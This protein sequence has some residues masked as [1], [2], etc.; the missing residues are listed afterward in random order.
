MKDSGSPERSADPR[1]RIVRARPDPAGAA[2][3]QLGQDGR[4]LERLRPECLRIALVDRPLERRREHV[5]VQDARVRVVEDRC[6]DGAG[7]ERLG[8][9]HE[10]LVERVLA[11]DEDGDAVSAAPRAAPLLAQRRDRAGERDRDRAVERADVDPELERVG[12]G[13]A[14]QLAGHQPPLD[15]APLRGRVAGAVGREPLRGLRVHALDGEAVDQLD[16]LA[17]LR[18]ADRAQAAL[19]EAGEQP[20][21]LAERA[22]P[23]PEL[24]I[25]ERRVPE[26]DRPLRPR[27]RIALDHR[28]RLAEQR[29]RELTGVRDRRRREHEL[30]LGAVDPRQPPQPPEH[31]RDVRAEDAAIDVRLVDD[32]EAE[33]REHVAP[34]VVPREDPDVEHVRVRQEHVRPL[35]DL[36]ALLGLRVAVVDRR[37]HALQPERLQRARLILRERLRRVEVERAALRLAREQVE[38]GQVEGEAL[39]AR[40][41]GRDDQV[42]AGARRLP[43]LGLMAPERRDPEPDERGGDSRIEVVGKGLG[44]A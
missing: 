19:R 1:G 35:A 40:G 6:L 11:R 16:R 22:R 8:I 37:L 42:A 34:A 4:P 9:A 15:L 27:R 21:R 26:R 41:A 36:P 14:E 43:G 20:R 29:R 25:G 33:V 5:P 3:L 7:E 2:R 17:A 18:E 12:R 10:E 13:D 30:R 38:H 28:R 31:V 24:G 23:Q 32:D 39:A 44:T